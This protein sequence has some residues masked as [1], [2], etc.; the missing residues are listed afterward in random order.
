[1][2]PLSLLSLFPPSL[3]PSLPPSS[4]PTHQEHPH[5]LILVL[6]LLTSAPCLAYCP[7]AYPQETCF[8]L[9]TAFES[10][11]VTSKLHLYKLKE[12]FLPS[13]HRSPIYGYVHYKLKG[14]FSAPACSSGD[15]DKQE[16]KAAE[17]ELSSTHEFVWTTSGILG[18]IDP[19]ILSFYQLELLTSIYGTVGILEYSFAPQ[20][21]KPFFIFM[22]LE[23]DVGNITC[24]PSVP[25][26]KTSLADIT[27][28]VS[29]SF[30][31]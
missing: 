30:T 19:K 15:K 21:P 6:H 20:K 12:E 11:I 17:D 8:N 29:S 10:A 3:P 23:L 27:S 31:H 7:E 26:L 9:Y 18:R 24:V 1:M 22:E 25:Q 14:D 16:M 5:L 2:R 28:W 4:L 13:S